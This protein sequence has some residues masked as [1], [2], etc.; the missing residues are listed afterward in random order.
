MNPVS[1]SRKVQNDLYLVMRD[2]IIKTSA[3]VYANVAYT[4][5]SS[6]VSVPGAI[7]RCESCKLVILDPQNAEID[8]IEGRHLGPKSE[9]IGYLDPGNCQLLCSKCHR[10]KTDSGKHTD[11][12]GPQMLAAMAHLRRA[13]LGNFEIPPQGRWH[14]STYVPAWEKT[15]GKAH[16]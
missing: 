6:L 15:F 1:D 8:H 10:I 2:Y 3:R 7:P 11:F 16:L 13:I 9:L 12:R 14:E 5:N 4:G